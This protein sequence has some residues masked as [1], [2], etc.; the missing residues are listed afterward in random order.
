MPDLGTIEPG[1]PVQVVVLDE[2]MQRTNT[3]VNAWV[4]YEN[5]DGSFEL[6]D[7]EAMPPQR[8]YDPQPPLS[9]PPHR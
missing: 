8:D 4:E 2:N 5:E 1:A 6:I 7:G 9:Q 3:W